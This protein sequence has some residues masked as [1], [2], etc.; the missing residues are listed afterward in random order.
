M[1]QMPEPLTQM[2]LNPTPQQAGIATRRVPKE[3]PDMDDPFCDPES[4]LKWA[5]L[6]IERPT[7][8]EE[9]VLVDPKKPFWHY[10]GELS[11][12]YISKYSEDPRRRIPNDAANLIPSRKPKPKRQSQQQP[13]AMFNAH[14]QQNGGYLGY[15]QGVLQQQ[16]Q[17]QLQQLQVQQSTAYSHQQ[18]Q[19]Q[20]KGQVYHDPGYHAP[21]A[22]MMGQMPQQQLWPPVYRPSVGSPG[23]Q[24]QRVAVPTMQGGVGAH[25]T[26]AA[27]DQYMGVIDQRRAEYVAAAALSAS[28][29]LAHGP[30]VETPKAE[31]QATPSNAA[32]PVAQETGANNSPAVT[33][34]S[35]TSQKANPSALQYPAKTP[36]KVSPPQS[37]PPKTS[38]A[39]VNVPVPPKPSPSTP[40]QPNRNNAFLTPP[41]P[42][43]PQMFTPAP[44]PPQSGAPEQALVPPKQT[45]TK[46]VPLADIQAAIARLARERLQAQA[47]AAQAATAPPPQAA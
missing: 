3:V 24:Q 38:K 23:M 36:Q 40:F 16:H 46:V 43:S 12:E 6:V 26:P 33:S 30:Q 17:Q 4:G 37:T 31:K 28:P 32:A 35:P 29:Q 47:Q 22:P 1:A 11:T 14:M 15:S 45:P 8:L 34:V 20:A 44:P 42:P 18:Q 5:E 39:P 19:Q 13:K 27:A 41:P 25:A 10:L 2:P 21:V 9:Q 7:H